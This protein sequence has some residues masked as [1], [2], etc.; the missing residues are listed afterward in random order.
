M[1]EFRKSMH[2]VSHLGL[3]CAECSADIKELPFE[4]KNDRPVY[5]SDCARKRRPPK[6]PRSSFGRR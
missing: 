6:G 4:P 3:R 1:A 5:C 2:D